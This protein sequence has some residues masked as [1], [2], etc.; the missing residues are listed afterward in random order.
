MT[1]FLIENLHFIYTGS[2]S[3]I[4]YVLYSM[5]YFCFVLVVY[6]HDCHISF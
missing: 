6:D 3:A 2:K 5:L 4:L 1:S